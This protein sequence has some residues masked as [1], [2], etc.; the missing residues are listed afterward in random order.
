MRR[1][2]LV[3]IACTAAFSW[4]SPPGLAQPYPA[5]PVKIIVPATPG[6]TSDIYARALGTRLPGNAVLLR[7]E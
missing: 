4:L 1:K 2:V 5:K 3:T 7:G 6:G